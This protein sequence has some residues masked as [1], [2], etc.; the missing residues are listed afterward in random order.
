MADRVGQQ[1][2]HYRLSRFLGQG[3]FGKVYLGEHVYSH[4]L[5][6]VKV[7]QV[8]LTAEDL[9]EFINEASTMFRMQHSH[10][11]RL[12]D[13]GIGSENT[14]FLVMA[15]AAN[16]TLRKL[17]P[18]GT[19][20]PL[21]TIIAYVSPIASALQHAHDQRLIHRDVKPENILLGP[22][23]EV[24]LSDFGIASVAHS[25]HS[26]DVERPGG[27]VPYMAPE[28]LRGK[29]R[30]ASDQYALGIMVYEWL[31]GERPFGG[32]A[33]EIAMQHFLESPPSLREKMPT[34]SPA[35]EHVVMTALA[36][37]AASRWPSVQAFA[38]AL[39]VAAGMQ[40]LLNSGP[41]RT[42]KVAFDE[43]PTS[44]MTAPVDVAS[45]IDQT[46]EQP[47]PALSSKVPFPEPETVLP[48]QTTPFSSDGRAVA[49]DSLPV[50]QGKK[51][52]PSAPVA[53]SFPPSRLHLPARR[54]M[55]LILL[56]LVVVGSGGIW[57][58]LYVTMH[59]PP[60]TP[61]ATANIFQMTAI[62]GHK[63]SVNSPS[64]FFAF[65]LQGRATILELPG[66]SL[67]ESRTYIGPSLSGSNVSVT[68]RFQ[69]VVIGG[70]HLPDMI[71]YAG[72]DIVVFEN[73]GNYFQA[74]PSNEVQQQKLPGPTSSNANFPLSWTSAVVGHNDSATHPSDFLAI[75][76]RGQIV[77]FEFP[78]GDAA[79]G[80]LYDGPNLSGSGEDQS[81][82]TLS[83]D[84]R[85]QDGKLDLT[86]NVAG[87]QSVFYNDGTKFVASPP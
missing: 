23:N 49:Q 42:G 53:P 6:A 62:V 71:V 35:V 26:L 69:K 44:A 8:Q 85:N 84:D 66:G 4:K 81:V 31:C 70:G 48:S 55:I 22:H 37:D 77:V 59:R 87:H 74:I 12:L 21:E 50:A 5:V 80:L 51:P 46:N 33:T 14:P 10:I 25:T 72:Q 45:P 19:S 2:E 13:F 47:V 52:L 60:A 11:V 83:F 40:P 16:G 65:K 34:I 79:K 61:T 86:I 29:A 41:A 9:K 78:G 67:V 75:N 76:I 58:I 38:T 43:G 18:K 15:Y 3:S 63:D 54:V 7:L 32:T 24:W 1:F 82:P 64:I 28:Q 30:P 17:Y 39:E 36:K 20:L 68:L 27:T 56:A 73:N 57:A